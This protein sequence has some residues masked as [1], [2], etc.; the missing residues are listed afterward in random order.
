MSIYP[1]EVLVAFEQ[2][3]VEPPP[4]QDIANIATRSDGE[5]TETIIRAKAFVMLVKYTADNVEWEADFF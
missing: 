4:L 5:T 1:K 2:A 3:G